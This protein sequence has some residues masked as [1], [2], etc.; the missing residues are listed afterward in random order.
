[1]C[2]YDDEKAQ[3]NY[4]GKSEWKTVEIPQQTL[5]SVKNTLGTS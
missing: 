2:G 5:E 1:M 3:H 4:S